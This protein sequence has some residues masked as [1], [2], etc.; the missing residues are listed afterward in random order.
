M[1][2]CHDLLSA[3]ATGSYT[4]GDTIIEGSCKQAASLADKERV[5]F[6]TNPDLLKEYIDIFHNQDIAERVSLLI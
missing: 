4:G 2:V 6:K 5:S 3:E 1:V